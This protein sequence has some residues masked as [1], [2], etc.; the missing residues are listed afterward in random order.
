VAILL[1]WRT[2]S[3]RLLYWL[4]PFYVSLC[5]STVYI[6]AHYA[7]DAIMGFVTGVII[8]LVLL[9]CTRFLV[10]KPASKRHFKQQ[11]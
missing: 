10:E 6:Q 3:K 2:R 11:S 9:H 4:L 8:Y 1:A 7:I 5:F